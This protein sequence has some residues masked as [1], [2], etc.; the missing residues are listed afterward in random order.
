MNHF[1][2]GKR[3]AIAKRLGIVVD[4]DLEWLLSEYTWHINDKGYPTTNVRIGS[5][6]FGVKLHHMVVGHA[7]DRSLE[8]DHVDRNKLNAQ[9]GN[10]VFKSHSRNLLNTHISDKATG[11][12]RRKSGRFGV[13]VMR[14][15]KLH[16]GGTYDTIEEAIAARSALIRRLDGED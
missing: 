1:K 16:Q 5:H 8:V 14:K 13:Q 9:R 12:V 4:P 7:I 6:V 11:I 15:P 10:L 2:P 3:L